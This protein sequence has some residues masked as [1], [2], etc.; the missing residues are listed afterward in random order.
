MKPTESEWL[1]VNQRSRAP[2]YGGAC[3]RTLRSGSGSAPQTRHSV[4]REAAH[5]FTDVWIT[6]IGRDSWRHLADLIEG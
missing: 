2:H 6:I 4:C 3:S 5:T 1:R